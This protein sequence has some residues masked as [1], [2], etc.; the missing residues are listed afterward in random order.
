VVDTITFF[1]LIQ[2]EKATFNLTLSET[3]LN[4]AQHT[5]TVPKGMCMIGLFCSFLLNFYTCSSFFLFFPTGE[6][7]KKDEYK[8][9]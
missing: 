3:D 5:R 1:C 9:N 4:Y 6:K 7:R 2:T 8:Q